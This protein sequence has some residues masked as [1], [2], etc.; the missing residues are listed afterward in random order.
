M[1][2]WSMCSDT[3]MS[4]THMSCIE[5]STTSSGEY[6]VVPSM[7]AWEREWK[8]GPAIVREGGQKHSYRRAATGR[9]GRVAAATH[10]CRASGWWNLVG[11]LNQLASTGGTMLSSPWRSSLPLARLPLPDNCIFQAPFIIREISDGNVVLL[12]L[13]PQTK[14][15][16]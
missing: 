8:E 1:Q 13:S 7:I 10:C 5:P 11:F 2:G 3:A 9:P 6:T 14:R 4:A 16:C 15:P 12:W